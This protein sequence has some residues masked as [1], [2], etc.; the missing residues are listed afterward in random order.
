[1]KTRKEIRSKRKKLIS[2]LYKA[3]FKY[4]RR[5][6]RDNCIHWVDRV[7]GPAKC[8]FN[9][10]NGGGEYRECVG[11]KD[12]KDFAC[13]YTDADLNMKA[14]SMTTDPV[15]LAQNYPA[16]SIL[17]WVLDDEVK[18]MPWWSLLWT[19]IKMWLTPSFGFFGQVT[20]TAQDNPPITK[21]TSGHVTLT[22][23]DNPPITKHTSWEVKYEPVGTLHAVPLK[24]PQEDT[25]KSYI[26]ETNIQTPQPAIPK[27][28]SKGAPINYVKPETRKVIESGLD[29]T[30]S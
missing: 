11:A 29:D 28:G 14:L 6:E 25:A 22:T 20:L 30:D 12:C 13:R 9:V 1:M 27:S 26:H 15:Y 4:G 8:I 21:H 3:T 24:M 23:Q 2:N 7:Q 19:K 17:N 18:P 10:Q 16:L 5:V